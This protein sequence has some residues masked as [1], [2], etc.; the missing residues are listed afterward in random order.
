MNVMTLKFVFRYSWLQREEHPKIRKLITI[1]S[2]R[3]RGTPPREN[4]TKII[5]PEYFCVISGGGYGKIA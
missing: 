4:I 1:P 5:R 3:E 2:H